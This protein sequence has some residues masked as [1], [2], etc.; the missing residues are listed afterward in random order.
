MTQEQAYLLYAQRIALQDTLR[1]L[2]QPKPIVAVKDEP[3]PELLA[4]H[5]VPGQL[6]H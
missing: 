2:A 4:F 1:E 6:L 3:R 5:R